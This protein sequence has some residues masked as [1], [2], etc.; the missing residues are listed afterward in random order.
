MG[1]W[2]DVGAVGVMWVCFME[3]GDHVMLRRVCSL[4]EE[5]NIQL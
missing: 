3:R 5:Y 4:C 2:G 1:C